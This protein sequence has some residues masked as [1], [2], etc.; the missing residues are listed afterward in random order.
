MLPAADDPDAL[1]PAYVYY[2]ED[3]DRFRR[4]REV[5]LGNALS[6]GRRPGRTGLCRG[7]PEWATDPRHD[8][9]VCRAVLAEELGIATAIAFPILVG[10]KVAGVLEFFSAQVIPP[11]ESIPDVMT[12]VGMQLGRVLERA[13][14]EEHLLAIPEEIQRTIAQDLHDDVGKR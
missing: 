8:L 12:A 11:D 2:D 10:G 6:P 13:G 14:F 1:L 4:F 9:Q 7:R 5:T 3:P